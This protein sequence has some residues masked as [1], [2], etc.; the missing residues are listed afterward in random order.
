MSESQEFILGEFPRTLDERYRLSLPPELAVT[1]VTE[2]E[3]CILAKHRP[4]CLGL[5]KAA[6]WQAKLDQGVE[7]IKAKMRSGRFEG[8]ISQVQM[9]GRLLSTR[10]RNVKLAGRSRLVIPEG[11]REFLQVE[12]G[13]EV[14]VVGAGVCVELWHPRA[15]H[16]YLDKRMVKFQRLFDN[17][18]K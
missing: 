18:S 2:D 14:N 16:A 1:L 9:F 17:L 8:R 5:W 11:F 12:P 4:G 6:Q 13:G 15:W 7:L 3:E 10:H